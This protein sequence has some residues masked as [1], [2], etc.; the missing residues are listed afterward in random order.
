MQ[1]LIERELKNRP[2]RSDREIGADLGV[3]PKTIGHLRRAIN[4]TEEGTIPIAI[5]AEAYD[6]IKASL[7]GGWARP[8]GPDGLIRVWVYRKIADQLGE[9]RGT[10]ESYSDVILRIA[11]P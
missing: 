5:T 8:A 1:G 3:D 7:P 9:L 11:R 4:A 6:A 10:G 2:D